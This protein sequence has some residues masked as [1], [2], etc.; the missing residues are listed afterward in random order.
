MTV[1]AIFDSPTTSGTATSPPARLHHHAFVTTD[2]EATRRF[3][4]DIVGLPLVATWTEVEHLM[5][6]EE[7]EFCHT[8]YGLEE[9]G[10]LAFFQFANREF[11]EQFAPPPSHSL[12]RHVALLVTAEGQAGIRERAEAAGL[13]TMTMDHGYCKS[14]YF[15]DPNGLLLEF[16]VDHP[17]ADEIDAVRR[18]NAHRDLTRWLAGDHSGNND[19]RPVS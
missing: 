4:E 1:T 15:S 17:K 16:T 13:E 2:Q 19:W 11:S 8:M 12:F 3:Y 14:M 18:E 6:G 7:Q 5:G 9:G 10:C